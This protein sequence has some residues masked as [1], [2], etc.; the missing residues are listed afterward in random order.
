MSAGGYGNPAEEKKATLEQQ[1]QRQVDML[2]IYGDAY[3]VDW[4]EL[5][6]YMWMEGVKV[7]NVDRS[8]LVSTLHRCAYSGERDIANWCIKT[9]ANVNAKTTLG[10]TPLHFAVDGNR[11]NIVRLLLD[12]KADVNERALSGTT[13]L[14]LA[15]R[16]DSY[17]MVLTLLGDKEQLV[18]ID[19]ETLEGR[20]IPEKLTQNK[21]ILGAINKYRNKTDKLRNKQLMTASLKRIFRM[22]DPNGDGYI[23]PEEWVDTQSFIAQHFEDCDD[24]GIENAFENADANSDGKIDFEEFVTSHEA[25]L[26]ILKAPYRDVMNRLSELEDKVFEEHV[27]IVKAQGMEDKNQLAPEKKTAAGYSAALAIPEEHPLLTPRAKAI[28]KKR[29]LRTVGTA[30]LK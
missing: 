5:R 24:N 8:S 17:E 1:R 26:S 2:L 20:V 30:E 22:F 10:R 14:H 19:A 16:Q 15:C 29:T 28:S 4:N 27:R 12:E 13:P 7:N 21:M 18:D 11:S 6:Q 9:K 3:N 23:M 25:M